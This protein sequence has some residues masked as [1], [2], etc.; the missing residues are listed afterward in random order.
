MC[1]S[2]DKL[3]YLCK[4]CGLCCRL[5][6]S[7]YSHSQLLEMSKNN[8]PESINF[9]SFFKKYNS[10]DEARNVSPEYYDLI[11]KNVLNDEDF[12]V[13]DLSFYYCDKLSKDNYCEIYQKRPEICRKFPSSCWGFLPVGCG[14]EGWQFEQKENDKKLVR[15]VK[16]DLYEL[17]FLDNELVL[18]DNKTALSLRDELLQKIEPYKKYGADNW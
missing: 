9:L 4:K 1:Y 16:E 17:D 5:I 6:A 7:K 15:K 13:E 14:Y 2:I 10:N 12:N 8:H 11:V 3:N 18:K